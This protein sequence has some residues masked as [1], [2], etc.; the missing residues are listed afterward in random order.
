MIRVEPW[1]DPALRLHEIEQQLL[2][3]NLENKR[4]WYERQPD[5]PPTP[6]DWL[7]FTGM[8]PTSSTTT[9]STSTTTSTS[10]S[11]TTTVAGT[12]PNCMSVAVGATTYVDGGAS[13]WGAAD[14]SMGLTGGFTGAAPCMYSGIRS[15]GAGWPVG[16]PTISASASPYRADPTSDWYCIINWPQSPEGS[17]CIE[18]ATYKKAAPNSGPAGTYNI[19]TLPPGC[20]NLNYP[21][22][23]T[24]TSCSGTSSTTTTTTTS[25][26]TTG[27]TGGILWVS[28]G[29]DWVNSGHPSYTGC[30]GG[31][32]AG[33]DCVAEKPAYTAPSGTYDSTT[34]GCVSTTTTTTTSTTTTLGP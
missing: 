31:C 13:A 34:C 28:N 21:S 23:V 20:H 11:S 2:T 14:V 4:Q 24:L 22:T 5:A 17:P 7:G 3:I 18:Q 16:T 10:S 9:S 32:S 33:M 1:A 27:C 19:Q 29:T 26:T 30:T 25:T 8:P 6:P 15:V 12:C